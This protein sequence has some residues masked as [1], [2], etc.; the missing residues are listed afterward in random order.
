MIVGKLFT[1]LHLD[2]SGHQI[3]TGGAPGKVSYRAYSI[4]MCLSSTRPPSSYKWSFIRLGSTG[5]AT[6]R[7]KTR[8]PDKTNKSCSNK[9]PRM[10]LQ[11]A[12]EKTPYTHATP[13]AAS[14]R[15][16]KHQVYVTHA[17]PLSTGTSIAGKLWGHLV[18]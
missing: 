4:D 15:R 12:G 16:P 1:K 5:E 11:Q 6:K 13:P 14:G 18:F 9:N 8:P 10:C 3:L 7:A 2:G 17:N